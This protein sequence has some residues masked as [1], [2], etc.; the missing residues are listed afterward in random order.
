M[1][2]ELI[3]RRT[4]LS[5]NILGFCR[6]LRHKDFRIGPAEEADALLAM[7]TLG[8]FAN[9]DIFRLSLRAVLARTRAQ[10]LVF[11][12]LYSEYWCELEKAVDSKI[13]DAP[14][15]KPKPK[16]A[17]GNFQSIK[18]WLNKNN[19]KDEESE[20]AAY[21]ALATSGKKSFEGF[22]DDELTEIMRIIRR[23]AKPLTLQF[24]RRKQRA[25][26]PGDFDLRQTLRRNLRRGGD[27]LELVYNKPKKHRPQ[28]VLLCDVSKSMDL[29]SK[30][31]VQFMYGFQRVVS[32]VETFV[33]STS[34]QRITN[35]LNKNSFEHT[36]EELSLT[37]PG[38]SGGTRIGESLQTFVEDYGR[39][40][41]SR[42]TLVLIMSDGWDTGEPEVMEAAMAS[43]HRQ[44]SK[45][46]WVNPLAGS[47]GYEPTVRGLQAALPYIDLFVAA[48]DVESLRRNLII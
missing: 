5:E 42:R 26:R 27:I 9:P 4:S 39:R 1:D 31:L 38:W 40:L 29:Y 47:P 10:Q 13:K 22:S 45:V 19:K 3:V 36:L 16:P 34:L 14:E 20:A 37:V 46:I 7:E 18:D 44:A 11:D 48:Y 33:F 8:P 25:R 32:R 21:S 12:E 28:L 30:F 23:A 35:Q 24:N 43:I 15:E 17:A 2:R 41:L 6:Y